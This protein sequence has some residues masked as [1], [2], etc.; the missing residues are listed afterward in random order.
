MIDSTHILCCL[1]YFMWRRRAPEAFAFNSRLFSLILRVGNRIS[2][3]AEQY[4]N[5]IIVCSFTKRYRGN[6]WEYLVRFNQKSC[7]REES[8]AIVRWIDIALKHRNVI[9]F[10]GQ[11]FLG[12]RSTSANICKYYHHSSSRQIFTRCSRR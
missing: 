5:T 12:K 1:M 2:M 9:S 4:S 10:L 3:H 6:L 8:W 11:V 7:R